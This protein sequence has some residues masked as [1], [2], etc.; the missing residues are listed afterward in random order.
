MMPVVFGRG[1]PRITSQRVQGYTMYKSLFLS[2]TFG[3][4]LWYHSNVILR[5]ILVIM[6]VISLTVKGELAFQFDKCRI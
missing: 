6:G 4:V 3:S 2:T 1:N 5:G